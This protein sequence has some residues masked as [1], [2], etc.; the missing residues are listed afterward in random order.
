MVPVDPA[1]MIGAEGR[2]RARRPASAAMSA[3][4]RR[5][6]SLALRSARIFGQLSAAIRTNFSVISN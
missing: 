3:L 6:G 2:S 4:R 5:A 1:A